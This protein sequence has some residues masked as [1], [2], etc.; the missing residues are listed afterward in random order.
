MSLSCVPGDGDCCFLG[1]RERGRCSKGRSL[2]PLG[3]QTSYHIGLVT[4][5]AN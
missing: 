5:E 1:V 2:V 3:P 4:R